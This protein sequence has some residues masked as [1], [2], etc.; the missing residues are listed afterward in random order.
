MAKFS[1][2]SKL[3]N[4]EQGEL[5]MDLCDAISSLSDSKE[6]AQFLKDLLSPQEAEMLAK[7]IKI[8][9]LLLKD[10]KY[11]EIREILKVGEGTVARVSEWLK[12]TGDG[13]RLVIERLKEKRKERLKPESKVGLKADIKKLERRYPVA[14][15]PETLIEGLIKNSKIKNKN[16]ILKS[17]DE[18]HLKPSLYKRVERQLMKS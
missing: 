13:Y 8:A 15:W 5:L 12:F 9:E 2:K 4:N 7:R 17:L 11:K 16:K 1:Y 18:M 6:A 14:F 10:W 3:T